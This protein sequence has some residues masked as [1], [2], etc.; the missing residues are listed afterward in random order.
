MQISIEKIRSALAEEGYFY[1]KNVLPRMAV[2]SVL[3]DAKL[4]F[5]TQMRQIGV[6]PADS[7]D[8]REFSRA[9]FDFFKLDE[10]RFIGAAKLC[11]HLVSLHRLS[12][13]EEILQLVKSA[14]LEFPTISTRPTMFFNS[15]YLAKSQ[16]FWKTPPHQDWRSMQGSLN[17][18][19]IWVP[20][21]K[22]DRELGA[23]EV[24]PR[25]HR[26]GLLQSTEDDFYRTLEPDLFPDSKFVPI[27][28]EAGDCLIFSSF[29][30]HR[31]GINSTERIRWSCH[32][33]YNDMKEKTFVDRLF[34]NPYIYKPQQELITPDFPRPEHLANLFLGEI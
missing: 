6:E 11:Q 10:K 25:S 20:L 15:K 17:S 33:R 2:D 30:A 1:L 32:F 19:V 24:V 16:G 28:V 23:L 21:L 4:I 29:L 7:S 34:P 9:M 13:S 31:S 22:V 27:E 8:E 26:E 12:L 3:A 18:V 14:G 5:L